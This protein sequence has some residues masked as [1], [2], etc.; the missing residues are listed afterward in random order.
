MIVNNDPNLKPEKTWSTEFTIERDLSDVGGGGLVRGTLFTEKT[1][2]ALYSQTNFNVAPNVTNIQN[3]GKVRTW[4]LETAYTA[5]DVAIKGLDLSASLTY[6]NS[7]IVANPNNPD[8][9]GKRQP[10]V[11]DWRASFLASYRATDKLATSLGVRY[12]GVQYGQLNNSDTNSSTYTGNSRY[13]VADVRAKYQLAKQWSAS[14]G[15]DNLNNAKYWAFH[16]YTQ[17]TYSAELRFD[18]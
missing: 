4:G 7:K 2:D 9:V 11:P 16:P 15:I 5:N 6:A 13:F 1:R 14:G 12:S 8:S 18:L 17:R 10:R 3:I